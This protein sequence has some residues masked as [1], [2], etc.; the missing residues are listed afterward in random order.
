MDPEHPSNVLCLPEHECQPP[1]PPSLSDQIAVAASTRF[2][3][4]WMWAEY[5]TLVVIQPIPE[6]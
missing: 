5:E 6:H 1:T 2:L 4:T 3:P